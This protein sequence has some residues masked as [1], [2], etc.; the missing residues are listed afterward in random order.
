M[1][2]TLVRTSGVPFRSPF[3]FEVWAEP[4]TGHPKN[5]RVHT[6]Q[7]GGV[8]LGAEQLELD[9]F[10]D[11]REVVLHLVEFS[12]AKQSRDLPVCELRVPRA[13][14]ERYVQEAAA[15]G[16]A[17]LGSRSFRMEPLAKQDALQ[18][19]R[20]FQDVFLP[21]GLASHLFT[22]LGE[23]QGLHIPTAG[24]MEQ[25]Q[26]ENKELRKENASLWGKAGVPRLA[27]AAAAEGKKAPTT[28]SLRFELVSR[29]TG[30]AATLPFRKAS[31]QELVVG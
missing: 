1:R 2:V 23:G 31:F 22:K 8:D 18:R 7:R 5:S 9:W 6:P 27:R 25:L 12:G 15:G 21:S 14:V 11:E 17:Y 30:F 26:Q 13:A 16:D 3:Y 29:H 20:R 4:A 19:K 28:V 24:E 10:G